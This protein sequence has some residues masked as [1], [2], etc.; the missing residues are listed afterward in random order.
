[1]T[2]GR[3]SRN[4]GHPP[5]ALF[6][7]STLPSETSALSAASDLVLRIPSFWQ[8]WAI[9]IHH[10]NNHHHDNNNT[11]FVQSLNLEIKRTADLV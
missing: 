4:T 11:T 6:S 7:S 1:M 9:I 3:E 5:N 10:G 8:R 2:A